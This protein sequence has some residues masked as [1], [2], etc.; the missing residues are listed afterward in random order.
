MLSS[1]LIASL[2]PASFQILVFSKTAGFRHDSIEVGTQCIAELGKQNNFTVESTE[3][4]TL[5]TTEKLKKYTVVVFLNTTMDVLDDTQQLAFESYIKSGKGYVGVHAAADTEYDWPFYAEL[6]GAQFM[7]HP[8]IQKATVNVLD[9]KHESTRHLPKT[10][11][12][13][14]EWYDY[15]A[16]PS[17]KV[18]ILCSLDTASYSGHKMGDNHPIAWYHN[19]QGGRS[20]YTGM[21]HTKETYADDNFRKHLLGGIFWSANKKLPQSAN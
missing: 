12:R 5:F 2:L 20:W 16:Q 18:H 21:G 9:Q 8:Q 14:D 11:E 17:D 7:S 19:Y 15:K 1:V 4:S 13:T 3:D 10:W 6:V